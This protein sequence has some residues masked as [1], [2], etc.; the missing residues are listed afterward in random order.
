MPIASKSQLKSKLF[1]SVSRGTPL[2][3][4]FM[5]YM[6]RGHFKWD[7]TVVGQRTI[8]RQV[9]CSRATINRAARYCHDAGIIRKKRRGFKVTNLYEVNMSLFDPAMV[10]ELSPFL[11]V[12]DDLEILKIFSP[13][14]NEDLRFRPYIEQ[15][16]TLVNMEYSLLL[17]FFDDR[18]IRQ[19]I[20]EEFCPYNDLVPS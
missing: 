15:N 3:R 20:S 7:R 5:A 4:Q 8:S 11:P 10:K 2:T 12:L 16:V 13:R 1:R 6:V 19:K 9:G 14:Y 17:R 18:L